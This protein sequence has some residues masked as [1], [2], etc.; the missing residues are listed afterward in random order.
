MSINR[1]DPADQRVAL[2]AVTDTILRVSVSADVAVAGR[3]DGPDLAPRTWH[4]PAA[5]L[6]ATEAQEVR[7]GEF[8]VAISGDPTRLRVSRHG[9]AVQRLALDGDRLRFDVGPSRLYGLGQG[10]PPPMNRRGGIYDMALNGQIKGILEHGSTTSAVPYLI[11]ANPS[12]DSSWALFIHRPWKSLIDLTCKPWAPGGGGLEGCCTRTEGDEWDLFLVD[13]ANIAD[14]VTGYYELTGRPPLPPRYAFGYQQSHRTLLHGGEDFK[15]STAAFFRETGFP[16]DMLI[17]LSSGLADHGWN[18]GLGSFEFDPAVFPEPGRQV[19]ALQAAG[20]K[21]NLHVHRCPSELHGAIGDAKTQADDASHAGTYW[22]RHESLLETAP[23][24]AWWPDGG[25]ELE[26]EARLTRHRMYREG[27]LR[28]RPNVRP[29]ALH[30]NG[31]AGMTRWGGVVWGGDNLSEWKTLERQIGIGLNVAVSFTPYWCSDTGGF[32]P[33][34]QFDGELFV[35]WFQYATFTPFL[36]AHGRLS[37]LHTPDGWNRFRPS[38][39]PAERVGDAY[40]TSA[41]HVEESIAPDARVE[42]ICRAFA[43]LRY[44]LLPY[45]YTCARAAYDVGLPLMRPMW[46]AFG[47]EDWSSVAEDQYL[48]GDSLLVA[49]VY[50]KASVSR[51][52]ALPEGV[53]HGLLDGRSYA[54][55]RPVVVDAPLESMPVF[56]RAGGIIPMGDVRQ[57]VEEPGHADKNGFDNVELHIYTGADGAFT[58]YEDDGISLAYERDRCTRTMITWSDAARKL[59]V[60][61]TTSIHPRTTRRFTVKLLPEGEIRAASCTYRQ[62]HP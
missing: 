19:A 16:C 34:R 25:D 42:P 12:S 9:R 5:V 33:T 1:R 8:V 39:V 43:Q 47:P 48:L 54:G 50:T 36:R 46:L 2:T 18:R 59:T 45:I 17:Y 11:G 55:D 51:Q 44:R 7:A 56:V 53:W 61:G 22:A 38:Q 13:G 35:R 57:Y 37:W 52:V 58:L 26:I 10:F 20:F 32:I 23:V 6:E 40:F 21:V 29:F 24:D 28:R 27:A 3:F 31:Y 62:L 60:S 14:V 41:D 4:P 30:R 49:P 15:D